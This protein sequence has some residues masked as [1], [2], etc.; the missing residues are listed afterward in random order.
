MPKQPLMSIKAFYSPHYAAADTPTLARLGIVAK[1]LRDLP[2]IELLEPSPLDRGKLLGLHQTDYLLAFHEGIEPLASSQGVRWSPTV[3]N[4][5]YWMLS[6]QLLASEQAMESG[7]AINL[8]RGFH[9]AVFERGS[10]Y[11]ALN[12]IALL[13]HHRPD[14]KVFVIDCDEHGGNGTEEFAQR[15]ENLYQGSIFGTR[16]G[17]LGHQRAWNYLV[18]VADDGFQRYLDSISEIRQ[19][20]VDTRPDLLVF[21]AGVD[22]H[23]DDPKSRVGLSSAQLEQRDRKV[24]GIAHDLGI[25]LLIV[26]GGGYQDP[27]RLAALNIGT[28]QAALDVF[29]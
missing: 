6:G 8:A 15:L 1:R 18:H 26:L 3:R 23:R 7:I 24:I 27:E 16:F 21:Q 10:G 4:A 14:H 9:H 29:G 13:A 2:G 20:I 25:P 22:C 12:G 17:C 5:F 28:L 11:C 19:H